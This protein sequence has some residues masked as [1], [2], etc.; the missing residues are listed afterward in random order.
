VVIE[1]EGTFGGSATLL[2]G[3]VRHLVFELKWPLADAIRMATEI[4]AAIVGETRVG[5]IEASKA[6]DFAVLDEQLIPRAT[7]IAGRW[8][9][10]ELDTIRQDA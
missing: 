3:M 2:D 4:P 5:S 8:V 1:S 7:M 6:A 9:H 10:S